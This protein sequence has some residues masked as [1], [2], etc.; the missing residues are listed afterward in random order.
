MEKYA[1]WLFLLVLLHPLGSQ[2]GKFCEQAK[3]L[4]LPAIRANSANLLCH[5]DLQGV[6]LLEMSPSPSTEG[7]VSPMAV[8]LPPIP[9]EQNSGD[10][11]SPSS[12]SPRSPIP[13]PVPI[14]IPAEKRA[15][16]DQASGDKVEAVAAPIG[17]EGAAAWTSEKEV[18]QKPAVAAVANASPAQ[19]QT[20]AA[21]PIATQPPPSDSQQPAQQGLTAVLSRDPEARA[22][23]FTPVDRAASLTCSLPELVR[24]LQQSGHGLC[25]RA[26]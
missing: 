16:F 14:H 17:E 10:S 4:L 11:S 7:N 2:V 8:E 18:A 12:G 22:G 15:A 13:D 1:V 9:A 24:T 21:T 26:T 5:A 6:R 19:S 25:I 20:P 3:H 23:T